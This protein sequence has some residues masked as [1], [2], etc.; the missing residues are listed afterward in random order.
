MTLEH[1]EWIFSLIHSML[2]LWHSVSSAA[3]QSVNPPNV[4]PLH[5][6]YPPTLFTDQVAHLP[7]LVSAQAPG[8]LQDPPHLSHY[9]SHML[10]YLIGRFL[11]FSVI[12]RQSW[13]L[14]RKDDGD[15]PSF[16][17]DHVEGGKCES[18]DV[19][20]PK[21]KDK[22]SRKSDG[23]LF[24][25]KKLSSK[26][27][28]KL[29]YKNGKNSKVGD[30]IIIDLKKGKEANGPG[31]RDWIVNFKETE[32]GLKKGPS[33]EV[34]EG[35][36]TG[37]NDPPLSGKKDVI[38]ITERKYCSVELERKPTMVRSSSFHDKI[39]H[40][41]CEV[42]NK[43]GWSLEEEIVKVLEKAVA[44]DHGACFS[45]SVVSSAP[46]IVG[47]QVGCGS[48]DWRICCGQFSGCCFSLRCSFVLGDFGFVAS[49]R[50]GFVFFFLVSLL[51]FFR[52]A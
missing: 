29:I 25:H 4:S 11:A 17:C 1:H 48:L 7:I 20:Q 49:S 15:F 32:D 33:E 28:V 12:G 47:Y 10:Y 9:P 16:V 14:W 37:P 13:F 21:H 8:L 44:F 31:L 3:K 5:R 52:F 50:V 22:M 34:I 27:Y 38:D 23:E 35:K 40:Q 18:R 30:H 51:R 24:S 42:K 39:Q 19:G 43:V 41:I 26:G 46:V 2:L 45:F 6:T 36:L